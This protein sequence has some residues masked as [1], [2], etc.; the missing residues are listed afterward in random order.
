MRSALRFETAA[1]AYGENLRNSEIP[2][3][4]SHDNRAL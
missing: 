2:E 1:R 3:F 4:R